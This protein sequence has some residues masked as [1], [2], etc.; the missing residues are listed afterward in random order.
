VLHDATLRELAS[1]RPQSLEEL[2]TVK[3][4]GPVKLERYGDDLLA[5][6]AA[7]A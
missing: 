3:G 1:L 6:L 7:T 4:F 2:A 5:V